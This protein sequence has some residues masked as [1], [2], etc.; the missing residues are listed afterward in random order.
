MW[1][2]CFM[3]SPRRKDT[4]LLRETIVQRY[5]HM[6]II[7]HTSKHTLSIRSSILMK[8]TTIWREFLR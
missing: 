8:T 5:A 1:N 2:K 7:L 4:K 3:V 6:A